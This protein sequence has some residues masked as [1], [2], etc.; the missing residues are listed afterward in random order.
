MVKIFATVR[1]DG[2]SCSSY[3]AYLPCKRW[4]DF[5]DDTT[6]PSQLLG[7]TTDTGALDPGT[8]VIEYVAVLN[9]YITKQE[10]SRTTGTHTFS[11]ERGCESI[12]PS[13]SSDSG[14]ENSELTKY[15]L[16]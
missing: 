7:L 13:A 2:V 4:D 1:K 11:I 3:G 9:H 6:H 12:L 10:L 15:V 16:L 5:R 8:Y 14:V